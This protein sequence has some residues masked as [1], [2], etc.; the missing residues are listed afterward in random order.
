[1]GYAISWMALKGKA[2]SNV[3]A[4]LELHDTGQPDDANESP[5]SGAEFPN[6]W[7]VLFLNDYSHPL[8][9]PS[10]VERLSHGCEIIVCLV[11]EHVMASSAAMYQNGR[12]TW[13]IMHQ[14][15]GD[16]VYDLTVEGTPPHTYEALRQRLTKQQQDEGGRAAEVDYIFDI[17]LELAFEICGY[18]HDR[19]KFDWGR[20]NF[21]ALAR[22]T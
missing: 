10:S 19:W 5:V 4:S 13:E 18:R 15:D 3:L 12:R 14:G 2:K 6:G 21:T 11:E 20:P 17:P 9:E 16:N 1:M 8:V 7:Y 22:K